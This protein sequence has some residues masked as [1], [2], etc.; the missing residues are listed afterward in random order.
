MAWND[1]PP[2]PEELV[3]P[4]SA[5]P[6]ASAGGWAATPPTARE[7]AA[8]QADDP[9]MLESFGRGAAQG[10]T[11]GFA[12]ELTGGLEAGGD[13]L[14]DLSLDNFLKNYRKHRDESRANYERAEK[15][16]PIASGL[17]NLTGAIAPALLSGGGSLAASGAA[18][19][20]QAALRAAAVGAGS[21]ALA[22]AGT[23]TADLTQ[24]DVGNFAGDVGKGAVMGGVL[25]G[26]MPLAGAAT[27]GVGKLA[28]GALDKAGNLLNDTQLGEDIKRAYEMGKSG[29]TASGKEAQKRVTQDVQDTTNRIWE[30]LHN[31]ANRNKNYKQ[32]VINEAED[33]VANGT[34]DNFTLQNALDDGLAKIDALPIPDSK[35][36]AL[37]KQLR[38]MLETQQEPIK[39]STSELIGK[40]GELLSRTHS[41]KGVAEPDVESAVANM[42]PKST[43]VTQNV[44]VNPEDGAEFLKSVRT[45]TNG[46]V[47]VPAILKEYGPDKAKEVI[48]QLG[49]MANEQKIS[50]PALAKQLKA[51]AGKAA[52][53]YEDYLSPVADISGYN[54]NINQSLEALKRIAK[55][56]RTATI[57]NAEPNDSAF[58][59][60]KNFDK[61]LDPALMNRKDQLMSNLDAIDPRYRQVIES[62]LD[63]TAKDY[64]LVKRLSEGTTIGGLRQQLQGPLLKLVPKVANFAGKNVNRFGQAAENAVTAPAKLATSLTSKT[65]DEI[66]MLAQKIGELPM[67]GGEGAKLSQVLSEAADRDRA[68]RNALL[69][70]IQQ[71]PAYREM[72]GAFHDDSKEK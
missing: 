52:K 18:G 11:F 22:G 53:D 30:S 24:G 71:N 12:D 50:N 37:A 61:D 40:D 39:A 45:T 17:G 26:A 32:A 47:D 15:A 42:E 35:K 20:G 28:G 70:A 68:G 58:N 64:D 57:G 43:S 7:L 51:M 38:E 65:P 27:K 19:L 29:L 23:S 21:G 56:K 25:G 9:S 6:A 60:V 72:L 2:K 46:E 41:A 69:F 1:T 13:A 36:Q 63:K 67:P 49:F 4:L 8:A 59:F 16:N 14:D 66:K 5:A 54:Q 33:R 3:A 10:A 62:K 31:V 55:S 48:Q 34:M 44:G